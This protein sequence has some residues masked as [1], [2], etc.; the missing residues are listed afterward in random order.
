[1]ERSGLQ[2][3]TSWKHKANR[4]PL[5][6]R[7]A[8]QVG[9]TWLAHEFGKSFSSFVAINLE[10]H[11]EFHR[12]FDEAFGK[13]NELIRQ[14]AALCGQRIVP[15][16]TLLFLDEVQES[17][18]ALRSLRYF[19]EQLPALHVVAA[20]S[21]IEFALRDL[22]F[23]VGRLEFFHLFPLSF[24]EFVLALGRQDLLEEAAMDRKQ[25]HVPVALHDALMRIVTLYSLVGGM[26]ESVA[27]YAAT[28][29]FDEVQEVQQILVSNYR[30]DFS[31]YASRSRVPHLRLVLDGAPR[32]LG[33]K[34]KYSN[35]SQELRARELS[36][37][38]ELLEEAGL[39]YRVMH[40]SGNGVPLAAEANPKKFKLFF[41][42]TGLCNRI[43]GLGL[44]QLS[45]DPHA[46]LVH[47][48]GLAE[49][50]VAQELFSLSR[51]NA[52]PH[53]HY[54]HREALSAQ[55]E[56]DFLYEHGPTVV[57]IEVKSGGTGSLKSLSV[58]MRE[59]RTAL[60]VKVSG[61][62]SVRIH[63]TDQGNVL[64]LPLY[65]V[66]NIDARIAAATGRETDQ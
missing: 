57:P 13:P 23:P 36:T 24:R 2:A 52:S 15:R 46:Q 40:S 41:L 30:A 49:Q 65:L 4:R 53:L 5:L 59:K 48:G 22:D 27:T 34:L 55:A 12:V 44:A 37:A 66:G 33:Q 43:M 26:P 58:F 31:K 60:G 38:V 28:Q 32:L 50:W 18:S 39:F 9:K 63:A 17:P 6:L 3:L 21:L 29:Q 11:P 62:N 51:N 47:R 61:S 20:G 25:D 1:M 16:E 19:R 42:D 10:S 7:G 35:L 54:W 64:D 14:L 56:V 45:V 8:R